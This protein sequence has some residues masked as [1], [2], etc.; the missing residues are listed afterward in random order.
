VT[1]FPTR[2]PNNSQATRTTVEGVMS[3]S[4]FVHN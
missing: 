3:H 2:V 4:A 1:T